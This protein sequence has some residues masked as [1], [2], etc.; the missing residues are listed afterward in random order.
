MIYSLRIIRKGN[1]AV[2]AEYIKQFCM[3]C[4]VYVQDFS[5]DT[6]N[7]KDEQEVDCNIWMI[8]DKEAG[9]RISENLKIKAKKNVYINMNEEYGYDLSSKEKR[10]DFGNRIKNQML[11][12]IVDTD[13]DVY[14]VYD[15]FVKHDMAYINFLLHLYLNHFDETEKEKYLDDLLNCINDFYVVGADF[16][17]SVF[18]KFAYLNCCRKANRICVANRQIPYFNTEMIMNVAHSLSDE[19]ENFF[20]GNVLAGLTGLTEY[21]TETRGQ[22]YLQQV[23]NQERGNQCV[24]FMYYALGHYY[25]IDRHDWRYGWM[26]YKHIVNVGDGKNIKYA[27]KHVSKSIRDNNYRRAG[28]N[29]DVVWENISEIYKI[30]EKKYNSGYMSIAELEYWYRCARIMEEISKENGYLF[31]DIKSEKILD[32]ISE[33]VFVQKLVNT[34]DKTVVCKYYQEKMVY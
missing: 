2:P 5:L 15:I 9:K 16:D 19:I 34:E 13:E 6:C 18:K 20:M 4:G 1:Q 3:F 7:T 27:L 22:E 25:E 33:N 10:V 14:E 24:G 12:E 28:Y 23:I 30:L 11:G 31:S 26:W 17:G 32:L 8:E 21:E 29:T